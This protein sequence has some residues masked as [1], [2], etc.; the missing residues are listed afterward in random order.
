MM[1]IEKIT[2][3]STDG[4]EFDTKEDAIAHEQVT[5]AYEAYQAAVKKLNIAIAEKLVTAD[6]VPFKVCGLTSYYSIFGISN[7][8]RPV[9][10][11]VTVDPWTFEL[12]HNNFC[13]IKCVYHDGDKRIESRFDVKDLYVDQRKAWEEVLES[14]DSKKLGLYSYASLIKQR[15]L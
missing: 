6:G 9:V 1:V 3:R 15:C 11:E 7:S 10:K 12:D 2:F 14:L 13:Y 8:V 5:E 4:T